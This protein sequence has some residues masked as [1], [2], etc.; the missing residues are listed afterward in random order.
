[1]S[2]ASHAGPASALA[3]QSQRV[4]P[5]G[6]SR[7]K[8]LLALNNSLVSNLELQGVLRAISANVLRVMQCDSAGVALVDSDSNQL[9]LYAL[10][11]YE[12]LRE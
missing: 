9:R 8:L 4:E 7:L 11:G 6:D 5:P 1:M 10:D 2:L 12:V 3:A